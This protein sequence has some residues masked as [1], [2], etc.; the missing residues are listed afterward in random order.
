MPRSAGFFI[1]TMLLVVL[2]ALLG[3]V[4]AQQQDE[5]QRLK[6]VQFFGNRWYAQQDS[7]LRPSA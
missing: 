6:S 5:Y 3:S 7:N 1:L 2:G 4:F